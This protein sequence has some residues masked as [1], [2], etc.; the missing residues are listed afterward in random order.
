LVEAGAVSL[1][2]LGNGVP[3]LLD[4][5]VNPVWAGLANDKLKAMIIT[6]GHHLPASM[7]KTIIR[8]KGVE[9]CIVVSDAMSLAGL[10]PGRY[11]VLGTEVVLDD[12][13]K[14]YNPVSGYLAGSSST[15]L[16]CMNHLAS[17]GIVED[18]ELV[19]MGF[20]NPLKLIGL[21][22]EDVVSTQDILFDKKNGYFTVK[23]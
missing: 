14:L 22:P 23:Q 20:D 16:K 19:M 9:G 2:H 4:R 6:D 8:T 17:L 11:E 15:M 13:G 7:I 1:T 12:S 18:D 21:S 3:A 10:A 5:H